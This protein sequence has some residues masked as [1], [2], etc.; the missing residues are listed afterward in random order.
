[1]CRLVQE[2]LL[3][4]GWN[5]R[6]SA[7]AVHSITK[8][9]A[10][11]LEVREFDPLP[12]YEVLPG[13]GEEKDVDRNLFSDG[14]PDPDVAQ[15]RALEIIRQHASGPGRLGKDHVDVPVGLDE[16][17]RQVPGIESLR[18]RGAPVPLG[19]R[20]A[21]LWPARGEFLGTPLRHARQLVRKTE[22]P[23]FRLAPRGIDPHEKGLTEGVKVIR[24]RRGSDEHDK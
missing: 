15:A 17:F 9:P 22:S 10:D 3:A 14:H 4:H 1:L 7:L 23:K 20:N 16:N 18:D 6:R 2:R 13:N 19:R 12:G 8:R 11:R 24:G 5:S 21:G